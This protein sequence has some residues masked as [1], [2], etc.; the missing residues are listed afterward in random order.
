MRVVYF[1][2]VG[3][4]LH[5][6]ENEEDVGR[7]EDVHSAESLDSDNASL[8]LSAIQ[9]FHPPFLGPATRRCTPTHTVPTFRCIGRFASC[10]SG[11]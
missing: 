7:T 6:L 3:R 9:Y 4:C 11:L 8:S 10:D 1:F 2:D 5:F